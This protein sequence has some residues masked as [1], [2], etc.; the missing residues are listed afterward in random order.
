MFGEELAVRVAGGLGSRLVQWKMRLEGEVKARTC[1]VWQAKK[2]V[3][4][5][6]GTGQP[7]KHS[8][9]WR[10]NVTYSELCPGDMGK[11]GMD[12]A[13]DENEALNIN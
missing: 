5:A 11:T 7:L 3:L 6:G 9:F 13:S 4:Y 10:T 12:R 2:L 1:N 8:R